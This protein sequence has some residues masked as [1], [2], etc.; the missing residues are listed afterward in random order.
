MENRAE[1]AVVARSALGARLVV[2]HR[3]ARSHPPHAFGKTVERS[4]AG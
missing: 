2:S 1:V 3:N 4:D